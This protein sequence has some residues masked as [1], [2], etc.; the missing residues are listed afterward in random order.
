MNIKELAAT[1]A[2]AHPDVS[3]K[4][5]TA[6]LTAAFDSVRKELVS[7]EDER[8]KCMPLGVFKI[9]TKKAKGA[10]DK[11]AEAGAASTRRF[12]LRLPNE[13]PD[14]PAKVAAKVAAKADKGAKKGPEQEAKIAER[15][16][17]RKAAP[18]APPKAPPKAE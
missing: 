12:M 3:P 16:A 4:S 5:I 1:L 13:K 8:I 9:V 2:A 14:K 11:P 15:K 7:T 17:A 18:K 10:E 6:L